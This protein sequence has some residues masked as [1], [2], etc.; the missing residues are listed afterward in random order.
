MC[1]K[2]ENFDDFHT[3]LSSYGKKLKIHVFLAKM[4]KISQIYHKKCYYTHFFDSRNQ[5]F[6]FLDEISEIET[7]DIIYYQNLKNEV[8]NFILPKIRQF[9]TKNLL[10]ELFCLFFGLFKPKFIFW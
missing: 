4:A 8:A 1:K 9:G 3:Y 10:F 7:K 6:D 5:N 2:I